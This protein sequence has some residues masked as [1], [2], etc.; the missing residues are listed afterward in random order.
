M[1]RLISLQVLRK[2]AADAP[3]ARRDS[4]AK[5]FASNI[6]IF[7]GNVLPIG[8]TDHSIPYLKYSKKRPLWYNI[9]THHIVRAPRDVLVVDHSQNF[10]SPVTFVIKVC[11]DG[12]RDQLRAEIK[13]SAIPKATPV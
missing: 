11:L 1:A 12:R 2:F 6:L 5:H 3:E 10:D 9:R 4:S 7:T 13:G 8:S